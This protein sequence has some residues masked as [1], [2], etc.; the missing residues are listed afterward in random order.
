MH[1]NTHP[2]TTVLMLRVGFALG[3]GLF[4]AVPA[5]A[6]DA[7]PAASKS[8][9]PTGV[10]GRWI[11]TTVSATSYYNSNHQYLGNGSGTA[12]IYEFDG[13]G[14]FTYHLTMEMRTNNLVSRVR[15]DCKGTVTFSGSTFTLHPASGHY[16]TEFGSR[17]TDRPM[18]AEDLGR[19]AKTL[20]WRLEKGTDGKPRFI[21]PFNDGSKSEFKPLPDSPKANDK[22]AEKSAARDD[23]KKGDSEFRF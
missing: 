10:A 2:L 6:Q 21:I 18:N 1:T 3:M 11:A 16:H 22:N 20:A 19:I 15:N 4:G 13:K 8:A 12:Q 7:A 9:V 14:G 23:K 17:I 5:W